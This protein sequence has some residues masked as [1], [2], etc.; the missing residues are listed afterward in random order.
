M[1]RL[2]IEGRAVRRGDDVAAALGLKKYVKA[3]SATASNPVLCACDF[4]H[5]TSYLPRINPGS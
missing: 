1:A 5:L 3:E 2:L 4:G